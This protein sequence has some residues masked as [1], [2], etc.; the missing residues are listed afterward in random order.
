MSFEH[1]RPSAR[2]EKAAPG[3]VFYQMFTF[4]FEELRFTSEAGMP[5]WSKGPDSSTPEIQSSVFTERLVCILVVTDC[6]GS[7]PTLSARLHFVSV[8]LH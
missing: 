7:N 3:A 4:I 5:E 6:V 1:R 2:A 8:T